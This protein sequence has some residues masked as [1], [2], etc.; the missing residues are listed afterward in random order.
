METKNALTIAKENSTEIFYEEEARLWAELYG[1][2]FD[3]PDLDFLQRKLEK[4]NH[5]M[6]SLELP[7]D[8]YIPV[9]FRS[10]TT[11]MRHSDNNMDNQKVLQ[12]SAQ[13]I[14]AIVLLSQNTL[15]IHH[16]HLFCTTQI[17]EI[18]KLKEERAAKAK[19][20]TSED[21]PKSEIE[22]GNNTG[23]SEVIER[24]TKTENALEAVGDTE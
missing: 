19:E 12:L 4:M 16:L 18:K 24:L 3:Q 11:Y 5:L 20:C 10:F 15:F 13:L 21:E 8:S 2:Q 23:I 9:L 14:D 6:T 22:E 1:K 7:W 17:V